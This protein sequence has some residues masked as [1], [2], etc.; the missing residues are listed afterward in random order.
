MFFCYFD[1]F[2]M[3]GTTFHG[4]QV[5]K[6]VCRGAKWV[7]GT[8]YME[9]LVEKE[10][11][12]G[13]KWRS[14]TTFL[15]LIFNLEVIYYVHRILTM[16]LIFM[17]CIYF[18]LCVLGSTHVVKVLEPIVRIHEKIYE[19]NMKKYMKKMHEINI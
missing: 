5:E 14:G 8:P 1:V 3:S 4:Y 2:W 16:C 9:Y 6:E 10:V 13:A 12:G 18:S 19:K 15:K 17:E 11:R 7:S